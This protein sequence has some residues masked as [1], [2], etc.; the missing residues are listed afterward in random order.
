VTYQ[1]NWDIRALDLAAGFLSDDPGGVAS[2][3]EAVD[4]LA[5]EPRPPESF[6]YGSSDLRRLKAGRYRVLYE[7]D[8]ASKMVEIDH[9]ARVL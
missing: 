1:I 5:E 9:V 4:R 3:W 7:V 8:E 2:L 6:P